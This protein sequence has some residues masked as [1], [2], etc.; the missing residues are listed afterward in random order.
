MGGHWWGHWGR[1]DQIT[2]R[3]ITLQLHVTLYNPDNYTLVQM[4][5]FTSATDY[6]G[7]RGSNGL[8]YNQK[9]HFTIMVAK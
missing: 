6:N 9:V 1:L 5:H 2:T 4:G 3:T 8:L 7:F